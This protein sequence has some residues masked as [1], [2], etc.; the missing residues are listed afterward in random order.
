M[1]CD[2]KALAAKYVRLCYSVDHSIYTRDDPWRNGI[3]FHRPWITS[4]YDFVGR[5][6]EGRAAISRCRKSALA[7]HT[8]HIC[9]DLSFDV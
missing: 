9:G 8:L 4:A 2:K 6:A 3:E 7:T 5:T 1:A